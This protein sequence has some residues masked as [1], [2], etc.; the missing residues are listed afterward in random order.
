MAST[1]PGNPRRCLTC[2]SVDGD[3]ETAEVERGESS[4]D[5][6]EEA[7]EEAARG[8]ADA[9]DFLARE[10]T[11]LGVHGARDLIQ[12]AAARMRGFAEAGPRLRKQ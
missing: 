2:G 1:S 10:T 5:W 4:D 9:L 3:G 12:R 8:I 11:K 6:W 7:P